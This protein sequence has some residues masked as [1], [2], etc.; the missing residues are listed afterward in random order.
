MGERGGKDC[1]EQADLGC[2]AHASARGAVGPADVQAASADARGSL[3]A[4]QTA[5]GALACENS[6]KAR[7]SQQ[8]EWRRRN[9]FPMCS[10]HLREDCARVGRAAWP[11]GAEMRR[12]CRPSYIASAAFIAKIRLR[13]DCKHTAARLGSRT[14]TAAEA[15]A[16]G[17]AAHVVGSGSANARAS[18]WA[19]GGWGD[20][21]T[22]LDCGGLWRRRPTSE[23]S[24]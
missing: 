17:P 13:A 12:A 21:D 15:A 3:C 22:Q 8:L 10:P 24:S 7:G 2:H 1:A 19:V 18:M 6:A 11:R 14:A 9:H 5:K 20:V 16:R 23:G 4:M